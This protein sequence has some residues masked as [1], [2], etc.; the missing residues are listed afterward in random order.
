MKLAPLF[1]RLCHAH[2]HLDKC[3]LLDKCLEGGHEELITGDFQE[4][5]KVTA[6]A[7]A[8]FPH[9]EQDLYERGKRLILQSVSA[10]VTSMRAHV[11]V[12]SIV[13][14]SCLNV[15]L[16]LKADFQHLCYIQIAVFA[17]EPL[18]DSSDSQDPGPNYEALLE[19]VGTEG[20]E[21]IGSAPYV[22]PSETHLERNIDLI[23]ELAWKHNLHADF[24]LDYNFD[25]NRRIYTKLLLERIESR[26]LQG[27]WRKDLHVCVGHATRLALP[28]DD[29]AAVLSTLA[30]RAKD[31]VTL[32]SLPQSDMYMMGRGTNG[33]APRSTLDVC[34]LA[35][36]RNLHIAMSVNNVQNAFT[37]QGT[38]DP[39]SLSSLGVMLFQAATKVDC[40]VLLNA[41]T[42][43]S[44][45]AIGLAPTISQVA[46][47]SNSQRLV[48]PLAN[49]P[50][51]GDMAD[52]VLLHG[53]TTL[54]N[55]IFNPAYDRTTIRGGKIV[56]TRTAKVQF[57]D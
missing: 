2:I 20:V 25:P 36:E 16:R 8:R 46:D 54:Q 37:P 55:A 47:Q 35:K 32:V 42:G 14:K 31:E 40:Q 5:L 10:G 51:Q 6:A 21:A 44:R 18:F 3:F 29:S 27:T 30:S 7:K 50:R 22:E 4:A 11:E 9:N 24:H 39:L 17:Q 1:V 12:D 15:G 26:T 45:R 23:L 28:D 48:D 41:V 53:N 43:N 49:I 34:R 19:V 13:G 57:V 56:A 38:V 33:P 52:F